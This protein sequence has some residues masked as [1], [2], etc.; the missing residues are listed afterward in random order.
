MMIKLLVFLVLI[1]VSFGIRCY[2]GTIKVEDDRTR[3]G[4]KECG[5]ISNYCIQSIN[6]KTNQIKRYCSSFTDEHNMEERCP[7]T[8]CHMQ[9]KDEHFCCCQFD[10]CNE[11]KAD[12]N[13]LGKNEVMTKNAT[14]EV[15]TTPRSWDSE[16]TVPPRNRGSTWGRHDRHDSGDRKTTT[17]GG[18][19]LGD[20]VDLI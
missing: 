7:M 9:N 2:D 18:Q 8:G 4:E 16:T 13:E 14:A 3:V 6:K 11:W 19:K 12:G 15:K 1:N 17:T 20:S 5:G 10:L